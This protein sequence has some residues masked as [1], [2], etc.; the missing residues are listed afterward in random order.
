ME[1]KIALTHG[2]DER[3][4]H[5]MDQGVRIGMPDQPLG[6]GNFHA[7]QNELTSGSKRMDI[8]PYPDT[9]VIVVC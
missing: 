4:T 2:S 8:V 7:A 9:H 6:V 1:A 5:S 3:I